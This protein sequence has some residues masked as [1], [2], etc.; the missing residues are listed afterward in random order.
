MNDKI[1][2]PQQD[3]KVFVQCMTYNQSKY[4]EDALN[5]FAL[6]ET[7]F[8]F[9][10]LV[11]DD[12]STDGEQEV[13][14]TWMQ[15]ECDMDKAECIEIELA[16]IILVPHKSNANCTF[17]FYLL[18][19][20][21]YGKGKKVP[22]LSPWRAH[23]EYEALCEGDDYWTDPLKLQKQVDYMESHQDCTLCV[24]EVHIQTPNGEQDWRRYDKDCIVSVED[25]IKYGAL[26]LHTCSFV[27]RSNQPTEKPDYWK[28][29]HVGDY[30]LEVWSGLNGHVFYF[31]DK[32]ATYRFHA[33]G[34][35][36]NR[37]LDQNDRFAPGWRTEIDMLN[38][39][40]AD[41]N[42]KYHKAVIY[43]Q[44]TWVYAFIKR[45][46]KRSIEI[47]DNSQDVIDLFPL[48]WKIYV[49]IKRIVI[50][51]SIYDFIHK[52]HIF[53]L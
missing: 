16:N 18:K 36:S 43:R 46:G 20:N 19:Q 41:S 5:G 26:W 52:H 34:S 45:L 7:N 3:Y 15:H 44:T 53:K 9:V 42:Y 30:P 8:P 32:M 49:K 40:D 33:E 2:T 22:L 29:C 4:I 31:A 50:N 51:W 10:C 47:M 1:Y 6:Q 24:S 21:I 37:Y 35:F 11:M 25:I 23:S 39:F 28:N 12:C 27:M 14:R 13:I 48:R 38:G 17:S